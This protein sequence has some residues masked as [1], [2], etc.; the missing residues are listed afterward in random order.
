[1]KRVYVAGALNAKDA[2]LYIK[3][4]SRMAEWSIKL[5][6]AGYSVFVPGLDFLLGFKDGNFHYHNYFYN[7]WWWIKVAEAI[8][9]VPHSE[10]S[11][12]TRREIEMAK[13]ENIPVFYS[14]RDMNRYFK[15]QEKS[16]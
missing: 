15:S 5:I 2:V 13:K 4:M 6:R 8:F 16:K 7:S 10:K 3:N 9:V 14:I 11:K 1:M 12:G